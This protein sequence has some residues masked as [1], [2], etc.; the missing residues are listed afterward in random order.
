MLPCLHMSYE[1]T[2]PIRPKTWLHFIDG[3][4]PCEECARLSRVKESH[5]YSYAL[6][7]FKEQGV[8]QYDLGAI[9]FPTVDETVVTAALGGRASASLKRY[10]DGQTLFQAGDRDFKFFVVKS[11]HVEIVDPSGETPRIIAVHQ[12]GEFTGDVA[13]L[14]GSPALV[15]AIARGDCQVYEIESEGLRQLLD[16][17][18]SVGD[19][20][21]QAFIARRQLLRESGNFTGVRIIGSRYSRD[22]FRIREFLAKNRVPFTWL[23]LEGDSQVKSLLDRF[24]VSESETPVVAWRDW[25]LRNPSTRQLSDVLGLRRSPDQTVYHLIVVGAGPAVWPPRFTAR[26]KG[27]ARWCWN[28]W[29]RE[30]RSAAACASRI[31]SAS[32]RG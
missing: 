16:R 19:V 24:A 18:P 23:D 28:V 11:G 26:R 4:A 30:D 20:I 17:S 15:S 10:L 5:T 14:T 25:L 32:R 8:A 6:K 12:P 13:H 2:N 21:L 29:R 7:A 9:A 1:I 3:Y 22:T 31:T 27:F